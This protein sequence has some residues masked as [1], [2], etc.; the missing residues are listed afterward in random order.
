VDQARAEAHA[1]EAAAEEAFVAALAYER[2]ELVK[3][4]RNLLMTEM[5]CSIW[6]SAS[7]AHDALLTERLR[8]GAP[9]AHRGARRGGG[10]G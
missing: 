6:K 9:S 5:N 4:A 10:G 8:P 3:Q 1:E 7:P 2:A